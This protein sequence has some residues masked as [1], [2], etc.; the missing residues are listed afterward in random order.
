LGPSRPEARAECHAARPMAARRRARRGGGC[1]PGMASVRWRWLVLLGMA[2]A[3]CAPSAQL[4]RELPFQHADRRSESVCAGKRPAVTRAQWR[5][6]FGLGMPTRA[7][8]QEGR[9]PCHLLRAVRL[10]FTAFGTSASLSSAPSR[11][12]L[13]PSRASPGQDIYPQKIARNGMSSPTAWP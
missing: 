12:W 13:S 8:G 4:F 6:S 2:E 1:R 5:S 9:R 10:Q 7:S 11:I 3:G